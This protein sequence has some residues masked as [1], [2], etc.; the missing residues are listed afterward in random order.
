M[1]NNPF[2]EELTKDFLEWQYQRGV[3]MDVKDF[4]EYLEIHRVTMS[5]LM[6]GSLKPSPSMLLRIAEKT[7]NPRYYDFAGAPRPDP[8][9][10]FIKRNWG[11]LSED[12]RKAL[13]DDAEHYFAE[14]VMAANKDD[15]DKQRSRTENS[16][17]NLAVS[18]PATAKRD[19]E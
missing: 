8:D 13:R 18:E 16:G 3:K 2:I 10:E 1:T 4:A 19:T 6:T 7:G 12:A 11:R 14:N 5:R 9:L 15:N 17:N